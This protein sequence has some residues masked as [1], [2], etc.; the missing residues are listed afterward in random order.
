MCLRIYL[1]FKCLSSVQTK[2]VIATLMNHVVQWNGP[3]LRGVTSVEIHSRLRANAVRSE[4]NEV[5]T[6]RRRKFRIETLAPQ[7]KQKTKYGQFRSFRNVGPKD[8]TKERRASRT[9]R[10]DK[11][12]QD[13]QKLKWKRFPIA[14]SEKPGSRCKASQARLRADDTSAEK[15]GGMDDNDVH[16]TS[17]GR[18]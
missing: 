3:A 7:R 18:V 9:S 11:T 4:G 5:K 2:R 17:L 1:I 10:R 12:G 16:R 8:K 15:P 6:R 14:E 13:N